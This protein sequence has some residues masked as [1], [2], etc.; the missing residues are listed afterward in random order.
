[1]A[2]TF[3]LVPPAVRPGWI[4]R[5]RVARLLARRFQV[6]VLVVTAPA[7]YGK[8]SALSLALATDQEERDGV[9]LWFQCEPRDADAD[10]LAAGILAAAGLPAPGGRF[11]GT[12]ERVADALLRLAPRQV[13]LVLDD[14][15]RLPPGSAGAQ[16]LDELV[17]RL[18]TNAH[19]LLS[20][21]SEPPVRL[22]RLR[23][24]GR[25]ADVSADD[26]AYD[27]DELDR[28]VPGYEQLDP[29]VARWPAMVALLGTGPASA[30]VDFLL[31]EVAGALGRDRLPALAALSHLRTVDDG[32]ARAASDGR[33]DARDLLDP[34]PLV[35]RTADG[36]YQMHDLWHDALVHGDLSP[37]AATALS[38][39]AEHLVDRGRSREAA[40]LQVVAGDREGLERAVGAFVRQPLMSLHAADLRQMAGIAAAHLSGRPLVAVLDASLGVLGDE[41]ASA[42]AFE[43]AAAAARAEGNREV[44]ALA[45]EYAANLWGLVEPFA[46]P[47][48]L[49][50]RA[51]ELAADGDV[52]Q[53]LDILLQSYRARAAQRPEEAVAHLSR[54]TP[55]ASAIEQV[56]H[57]FAMTDLG[58]PEQVWAPP[59]GEAV[60]EAAGAAMAHALWLRGEVSPEMGLGLGRRLADDEADRQLPH[61]AISLCSA[62]SI[63]A[64]AAGDQ[65][66]ARRLADRALRLVPQTS[67]GYVRSFAGLADAACLVAQQEEAA[68]AARVR[69]VLA[70][71][72]IAPWPYRSYLYAL[73][74]VY[75]LAPEA[76]P[77]IDA[78]RFGP[79]LSVAQA[80]GR[81]LV[82]LREED[83][84]H[85]AL[86]LP[87]SRP[88]VLRAHVLPPHLAQL[89]A[90][91]A[92][93]GEGAV[94]TLLDQL[95]SSRDHLVTVAGL[96]HE[97]TASWAARRVEALPARPPYDLRVDVL[98]PLRVARGATEL[99]DDAWV[100][101]ERVRQLLAHLVLHR[102]VTRRR[103]VEDLWPELPVERALQNLR[104]NLSH[105]QRVLQPS[106]EVDERPWFVRADAESLELATDGVDV[107][108]DRFERACSGARRLDE[109]ARGTRAIAGYREAAALFRGDYLVDW[110]D[111]EWTL[112]ERVRLR[113][114]ATAAM[115][116]LGELL[117]A[118]GEPEE[119]TAWAAT[120]LRH[121]PLLERGHRLFV[122]GLSGQGNRPAG[123]A[124]VRDVIEL[125]TAEGLEPEPE[126]TRLAEA[127]GLR[128]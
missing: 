55:G 72:P 112:V 76:R 71:A 115:C 65:E 11:T 89:A 90:A 105:L 21:R 104:V 117:L 20:G 24:Q 109:Q 69:D 114:L 126:T 74:L 25:T 45:L 40:E 38:R 123:M 67:S 62:L 124:A 73:P 46:F 31:D 113:T 4:D 63:I 9:D 58:R 75:A 78:A 42:Q 2:D 12:A 27:D 81:A 35:Q 14:V 125:L 43:A 59:P 53:Q 52:A 61:V 68:A 93:A 16:L 111:A 6:D 23:A 47:D 54:L 92:A 22:A 8:T 116:R 101:R 70:D 84:P 30:T 39:V 119:A 95:P 91:A 44:E 82:A 60:D 77:T 48:A 1:M 94:G 118:R 64:V 87:W 98:G 103:V 80:A 33:F 15:H 41:R 37:D 32:I 57:V 107:D 83:D 3:R 120:V 5:P 102:R 108:A 19:V 13:C 110:P 88:Q 10:V 18:P 36:V 99:A 50:E 85:P 56:Q 106:R 97:P 66:M 96:A 127:L 79:A 122:R 49:C 34:L 51:A 86:D 7:G 26:L 100:R 17:G 121:E 29:A 28:A 128:G